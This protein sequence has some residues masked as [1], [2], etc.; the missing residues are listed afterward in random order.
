MA[1]YKGKYYSPKRRAIYAQGDEIDH[2]TL[3]NLFGWTCHICMSDIDPKRRFPDMMAATVEH[4]IPL[5][6]GGLHRWDNVAPAHAQCNF[7]KSN[8]L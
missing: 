1:R 2:L 5:S 7:Q 6:M 8:S 4:I 3:F